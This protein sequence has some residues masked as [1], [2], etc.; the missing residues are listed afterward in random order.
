MNE[1]EYSC[2]ELCDLRQSIVRHKILSF[3]GKFADIEVTNIFYTLTAYIHLETQ[4]K[5]DIYHNIALVSLEVGVHF[6]ATTMYI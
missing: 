6:I 2:Q 1:N 4:K 3:A 5:K